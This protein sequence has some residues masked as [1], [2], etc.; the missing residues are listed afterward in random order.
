MPGWVIFCSTAYAFPKKHAFIL[1]TLVAF[2][3]T[4][5]CFILCDATLFKFITFTVC[6]LASLNIFAE[7]INTQLSPNE[8]FQKGERLVHQFKGR[9]ALPYLKY[10]ADN[11][12]LSGA[13]L[14][15]KMRHSVMAVTR[16][17]HESNEYIEYA[18]RQGYLPAIRWLYEHGDGA[19][20]EDYYN[21]LILLGR[22]SPG[23][24]FYLLADYYRTT[25][26]ERYELYLSQAAKRRYP[27]ALIELAKRLDEGKGQYLVPSVRV[28]RTGQIYLK[29]AQTHDVPAMR[30]YIQWLEK[31]HQFTEAFHWR[32]E[33]L[34]A[35]DI[36]QLAS[37][38]LIYAKPPLNYKF[39]K[40]D[41]A[42]SNL[43][44]EKYINTAGTE[45][46][47][48]LYRKVQ[49]RH[50]RNLEKCKLNSYLC[51]SDISELQGVMSKRF[52]Y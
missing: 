15:G 19:W 18:A 5:Y 49:Q 29:A 7:S 1:G 42:K 28:K 30:A 52:L 50:L 38:G 45:R 34:N 24:A 12:S 41:Y 21:A 3:C 8:A 43:L 47:E 23:K 51:D 16:D 37:L 36:L 6:I 39:I 14:Y 32:F 20:Q 10:A 44:L 46:F 48:S 2:C 22:Q 27:P 31:E 11:G 33:A 9:Q 26:A 4:V 35:G 40:T 25:D 17:E 13:F